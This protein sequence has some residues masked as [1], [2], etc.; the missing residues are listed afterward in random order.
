MEAKK[1]INNLRRVSLKIIACIK[2]YLTR[3]LI[4]SKNVNNHFRKIL[5]KMNNLYKKYPRMFKINLKLINTLLNQTKQ[6]FP[7]LK[8]VE[9]T[10]LQQSSRDLLKSYQMFFKIPKS[11]LPKFH[12]KKNGRLSLRQTVKSNLVQENRFKLRKYGLVRFRTSREYINL[13]NSPEIKINNITISYDN[14]KYFAIVNIE[15]PVN[16]W[17]CTGKAK[18]FDLNSNQNH[19]LVSSDGDKYQFDVNHEIQMIKKLNKS[20]STKKKGSRA[21]K[22]C[23]RRLNKW[24]EKI[25]NKLNDFAQKLSTNL[26]KEC[27]TI[28]IE[29]NWVNILKSLTKGEENIRFPLARFKDMIDYKFNWYKPNSTGLVEVN[30]A[31]TS[32]TCHVC[33]EVFN[34]LT[35][36][37]RVWTC[38]NCNTM[39]DRDINASINILNR[40]DDGDCLSSRS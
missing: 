9:S 10:S 18:G 23:T 33:D 25:K 8:E 12:T 21:F 34:E 4:N 30:P 31:W 40:W 5:D 15:A 39:H 38:L 29:N 16:E 22:S 32:K 11:S 13:L 37:H 27:D 6:E 20:L 14:F 24:Y 28:V 7:F 17:S 3:N 35:T 36:N 2:N 26:V 1:V 19:F